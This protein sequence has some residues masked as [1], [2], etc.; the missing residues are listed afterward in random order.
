VSKGVDGLTADRLDFFR[1]S[2]YLYCAH[3]HKVVLRNCFFG[4]CYTM[5]AKKKLLDNDEKPLLSSNQVAVPPSQRKNEEFDSKEDE[6]WI[7][8]SPELD[9]AL[10]EAVLLGALR[11]LNAQDRP[12]KIFGAGSISSNSAISLI[13]TSSTGRRVF[14]ENIPTLS[15][16][17]CPEVISLCSSTV[18]SSTSSSCLSS[19]SRRVRF[20]ENLVTEVRLR[21]KTPPDEQGTLF[22]TVDEI[23]R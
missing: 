14:V 20:A 16:S 13:S 19:Y 3:A 15:R 6:E 23:Q 22:Y 11:T 5:T 9:L 17:P 1:M 8:Y 12:T 2:G 18:T 10:E 4:C 7:L 21:P